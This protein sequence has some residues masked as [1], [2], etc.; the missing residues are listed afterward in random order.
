MTVKEL[1]EKLSALPPESKELPVF[2]SD[3]NEQYYP[4]TPLSSAS[5]VAEEVE[6][7]W[8]HPPLL[9]KRFVLEYSSKVEPNLI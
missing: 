6:S 7:K 3:W 8:T 1:I 2:V 5:I 4:D 9:P